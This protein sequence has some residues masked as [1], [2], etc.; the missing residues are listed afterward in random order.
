MQRRTSTP[1]GGEFLRYLTRLGRL[2]LD[3]PRNYFREY[4]KSR[5]E[6]PMAALPA[7]SG[8]RQTIDVTS[9]LRSETITA[10]AESSQASAEQFA[11]YHHYHTSED[12][13]MGMTSLI[14]AH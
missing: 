9:T 12:S 7:T 1:E 4:R 3:E 2:L 11:R 14:D 10:Y 13:T 8:L 5:R 6:M